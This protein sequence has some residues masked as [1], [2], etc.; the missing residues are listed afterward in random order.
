MAVVGQSGGAA[1]EAHVNLYGDGKLLQTENAMLAPGG[2]ATLTFREVPEAEVYR[3][4]V[5]EAD[6]YAADNEAYA[7]SERNET[8]RILLLTRGNLF[9]EKAL[10]LTGA[11]VVKMTLPGKEGE[12]SA[13]GGAGRTAVPGNPPD[14]VVIDGTAPSFTAQDDWKKLMERTPVWTVGGGEKQ[15]RRGRSPAEA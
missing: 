6:D 9:L 1:K 8:A 15:D 13:P 3:A 11:E 5:E 7:F 2:T 10:Q 14:L 4:E 12:E